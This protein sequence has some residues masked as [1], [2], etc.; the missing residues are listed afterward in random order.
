MRIFIGSDMDESERW[1][2]V[3]GQNPN[4]DY[5]E[6][7]KDLIYRIKPNVTLGTEYW[8]DEYGFRYNPSHVGG[9][10]EQHNKQIIILGDS[11]VYGH[12]TKHNETY[13][14]LLEENLRRNGVDVWVDNAGVPGYGSDQQ[15][16]Y[17]KKLLNKY[18]PNLLIWNFNV[19]DV[20]DSNEACLFKEIGN[21]MIK[22][23]AQANTLYIRKK[24]I[25]PAI[26]VFPFSTTLKYLYYSLPERYTLF[27]SKPKILIEQYENKYKFFLKDLNKEV[28]N[29]GGRLVVVLLIN[30][31]HFGLDA[32]NREWKYA[33]KYYEEMRLAIKDWTRELEIGV[34]DLN[35]LLLVNISSDSAKILGVDDSGKSALFLDEIDRG[36]SMGSSHPNIIGNE[37]SAIVLTD[38]IKDF[39]VDQ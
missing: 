12:G 17:A 6:L 2:W 3:K 8:S 1:G 13:P 36:F 35:D 10:Q 32:G 22:I 15:Y 5:Y 11:F 39:L 28:K 14:Y 33:V 37:N 29:V 26:S 19:N 20:G 30:E 24:Y 21:R 9:S 18:S 38:I 4:Y 25:R 34:Y 16:V 7:D 31:Y 23:S 27:C